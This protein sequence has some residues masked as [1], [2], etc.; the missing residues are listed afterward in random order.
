MEKQRKIVITSLAIIGVM[1][2][3]ATAS[4]S[5]FL[6]SLIHDIMA[7]ASP[8]KVATAGPLENDVESYAGTLNALALM[9]DSASDFVVRDEDAYRSTYIA[10]NG[11]ADDS[12]L[13]GLQRAVYVS[14][15]G[16][17]RSPGVQ[18]TILANVAEHVMPVSQN[19]LPINRRPNPDGDELGPEKSDGTPDDDKIITAA[20]PDTAPV[21]VAD[22]VKAVHVPEPATLAM[23]GLGFAGL[24]ASRRRRI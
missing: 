2:G 19:T 18:E 8:E 14:D 4:A 9:S 16:N 12:A 15:S 7:L 3:A 22:T 17:A 6:T 1:Y 21:P 24:V 23:L 13:T 20:A 11:T 10:S 5:P